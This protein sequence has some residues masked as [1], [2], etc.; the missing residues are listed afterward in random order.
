[1]SEHVE[2]ESDGM[3]P[4]VRKSEIPEAKRKRRFFT[5]WVQKA[6]MPTGRFCVQAYVSYYHG[7]W[8][9]QWHEKKVG[10]FDARLL[11]MVKELERDTPAII[12]L[13]EEGHRQAEIEH[14]RWL[15]QKEK[16]RLEELARRQAEA[17]QASQADLNAIINDWSEAMRV[18]AFFRDAESKAEALG[19]EERS[20]II[21]RLKLARQLIGGVDA[22]E[23]FRAW[24]APEE[25]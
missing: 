18:E 6:D 4:Y 1:M 17:L 2:V 15:E 12:E 25:R 14:Q 19:D 11:G 23:R 21:D 7:E 20:A 13:V 24:K 22:L 10:D 3:G 9:K 16:W 5:D 8:F